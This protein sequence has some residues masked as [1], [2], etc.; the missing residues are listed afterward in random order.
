MTLD[1]IL[2]RLWTAGDAAV[3]PARPAGQSLQG[4]MEDRVGVRI[5]TLSRNGASRD[6]HLRYKWRTVEPGKRGHNP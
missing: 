4:L 3:L 5:A 6:S 1:R 2:D